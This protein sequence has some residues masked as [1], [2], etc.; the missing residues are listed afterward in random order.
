MSAFFVHDLKNAAASLN[1]MLKNLPVHFDDPVFRQ[2][3][4][5][6]IGNTAQR[7]D[8]MISRLSAVRQQTD[9][10]R[11][12]TDLNQIVSNTLAGVDMKDIELVQD[13]RPL[14]IIRADG[15][16]LRSVVTNMILNARDALS[17]GGRIEIRTEHR[18]NRVVLSVIDNGCGMS[19][20]FVKDSLFRPFQSTK[21]KGLGIGLFQSR[22]IILAHGGGVQVESEIGKGSSFHASFPVSD[23]R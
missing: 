7:I 5:R 22:A 17:S 13:L 1:L 9:A 16:Q 15:D 3:T 18:G 11:T 10:V 8:D 4:L 23:A 6:G 14:P 2:D 19:P 12:D 20:A 21:K